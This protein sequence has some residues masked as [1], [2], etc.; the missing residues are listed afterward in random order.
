MMIMVM[1][2][3]CDIDIRT[4]IEI[5]IFLNFIAS[6]ELN[7]IITKKEIDKYILCAILNYISS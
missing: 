3:M 4:N 2:H 1:V 7:F 6:P 5:K